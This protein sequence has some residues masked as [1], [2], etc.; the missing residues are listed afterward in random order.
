MAKRMA[1]SAGRAKI[2]VTLAALSEDVRE[3]RVS[4]GSTLKNVL[5]EAG[6]DEDQLEG[7]LDGL[8]VNGRE[9]GLNS[10]LSAGAFITLSPNVEGGQQ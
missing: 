4:R 7:L 2:S 6:Y 8:R 3:L 5:L 9:A 1:R 10:R